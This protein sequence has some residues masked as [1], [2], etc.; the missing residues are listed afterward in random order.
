MEIH[1]ERVIIRHTTELDLP[2]IM[3]LWNDGNVMKWVGFP[4]GAGYDQE[5]MRDWFNNLQSDTNRHHFVVYAEEIGFCGEVYYAMDKMDP[6]VGLD[7]KF[8]PKA[9]GYGLATDALKTLIRFVFNSEPAAEAVW[10]EPSEENIAA[11]KLYDRCGLRAKPRPSD[12]E[13]GPSY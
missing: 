3:D 1:G 7:I 8:S 6:R 11:R 12:L 13:K 5:K 4:D 9:Q 10:T 2:D